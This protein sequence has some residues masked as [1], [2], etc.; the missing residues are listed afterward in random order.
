MSLTRASIL[1][2][3]RGMWES[4]IL[5]DR[6]NKIA[7]MITTQK[8]L[9]SVPRKLHSKTHFL[10]TIVYKE[11]GGYEASIKQMTMKDPYQF[12]QDV[13]EDDYNSIVGVLIDTA[14]EYRHCIIAYEVENNEPRDIQLEFLD[15][16][17]ST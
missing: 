7:Y 3:S 12:E 13:M 5:I 1:F 15:K 9:R 17:Y 8:T 2:L 10:Q 16:D 14:Q 4:G 6:T 11:N